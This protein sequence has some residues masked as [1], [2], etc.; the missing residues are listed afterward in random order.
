MNL[1]LNPLERVVSFRHGQL[2]RKIS[3]EQF[4]QFLM[5]GAPRADRQEREDAT[6]WWRFQGAQMGVTPGGTLVLR[7][8][9]PGG[10]AELPVENM[11]GRLATKEDREA[12]T[13]LVKAKIISAPVKNADREGVQH[14]LIRSRIPKRVWQVK[15]TADGGIIDAR[16]FCGTLDKLTKWQGGNVGEDG[17]ICWGY[18]PPT[19]PVPC[20]IEALDFIFLTSSPFNEHIQGATNMGK[21]FHWLQPRFWRIVTDKAHK[22]RMV[23]IGQAKEIPASIEDEDEWQDMEGY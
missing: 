11:A 23:V 21:R 15:L 8:E 13:K 7:Q 5:A 20:P 19:F 17:S 2:T 22:E 10:I 18:R 3:F 9:M 14:V 12:W 4:G 1:A 6:F 16:V